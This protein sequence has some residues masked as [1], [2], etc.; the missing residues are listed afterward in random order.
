MRR[1][2]VSWVGAGQRAENVWFQ[3][4]QG[5]GRSLRPVR[6]LGLCDSRALAV[7]AA[8]ADVT[9]RGLRSA[10]QERCRLPAAVVA[11]LRLLSCGLRCAEEHV[12][13][14][15]GRVGAARNAA[16]CGGSEGGAWPPKALWHLLRRKGENSAASRGWETG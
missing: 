2:C 4:G 15:D 12:W 14:G 9:C 3:A 1:S 7:A 11:F 8:W 5:R 10:S 16:G 13:G 6:G